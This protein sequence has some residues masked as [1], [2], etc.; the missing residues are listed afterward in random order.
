MLKL[1][2]GLA[3]LGSWP[4]EESVRIVDAIFDKLKQFYPDLESSYFKYSDPLFVK[5]G[6]DLPKYVKRLGSLGSLNTFPREMAELNTGIKLKTEIAQDIFNYDCYIRYITDENRASSIAT[7][8]DNT[9]GNTHTLE[10]NIY[11][12]LL[13]FFNKSFATRKDLIHEINLVLRHELLHMVD[14]CYNDS[15]KDY[16]QNSDPDFHKYINSDTELKS[17]ADTIAQD[18]IDR[19]PIIRGDLLGSKEYLSNYNFK[20]MKK[21]ISLSI[22]G[23]E[24]LESLAPE[25]KPAFYNRIYKRIQKY[26]KDNA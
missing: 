10:L 15:K 23:V 11:L 26:L 21:D 9:Y 6:E 25:N 4:M 3:E 19:Y 2:S 5:M 20:K 14:F 16:I 17:W 8:K 24:L 22:R 1:S 7:Y 12:T 13:K 18:I